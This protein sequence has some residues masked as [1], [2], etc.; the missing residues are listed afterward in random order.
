MGRICATGQGSEPGGQIGLGSRQR[1]CA[2]PRAGEHDDQLL[3]KS[4]L[5]NENKF[6]ITTLWMR[7]VQRC[8]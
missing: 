3:A 1:R 4:E 8:R 5:I 7:V 6:S 2:R